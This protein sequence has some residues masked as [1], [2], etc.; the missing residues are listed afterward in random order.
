LAYAVYL[1]RTAKNMLER[2]L[3]GEVHPFGLKKGLE[4][5]GW[6]SGVMEEETFAEY[7]A[8]LLEGF[9]LFSVSNTDPVMGFT[10]G[11]SFHGHVI[12]ADVKTM[13]DLL[14][15]P[16][17]TTDLGIPMLP[18]DSK[19]QKQWILVLDC[20]N[21]VTLYDWK[22]YREL[23][24]TDV[25]CWHIGAHTSEI[26]KKA[27]GIL[28]S[29]LDENSARSVVDGKTEEPAIEQNPADSRAGIV[30][31]AVK[32][33][34]EARI[35][36]LKRQIDEIMQGDYI[37]AGIVLTKLHSLE[38]EHGRLTTAQKQQEARA[39]EEKTDEDYRVTSWSE[40][41]RNAPPSK[42]YPAQEKKEEGQA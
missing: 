41:G 40:R 30:G 24:P 3:A 8:T 26:A 4:N 33:K 39:E 34:Q 1:K 18:V 12:T 5:V 19:I 35:V 14:G 10:E 28:L 7:E 13:I 6:L 9:D 36:E 31:E 11:T 42:I 2:V 32:R 16:V 20:G 27:E 29:A 37:L 25:I 23:D 22:E 38:L 15:D 21:V 17:R